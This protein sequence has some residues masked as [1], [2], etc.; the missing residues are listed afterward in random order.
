MVV[1]ATRDRVEKELS[2][3]DGI[4]RL[5]PAWVGRDLLPSGRRLG[6]PDDAY[7]LGERGEMCE[8][9]LGSTTHA[10]NRVGPPDE[11][12]SYLALDGADG[13]TL[14]EA[15]EAAPV[16]IMGTEYASAHPGLSRLAKI[17]DYRGRL[18]LHLHQRQEHAALVGRHSKDEAYYFPPG[19]DLGPHPETFL[20]VHPS[21]VQDEDYEVLLPY[22]ED[23]DSDLILRHSTAYVQVPEEGF[24]VPSG[25]LHGPGTAL[26]IELQEDSDVFAML[27][28]LNHGKLISKELLWKDVSKEDREGKGERFI[29][30]LIDWE[31]NGDPYLY[32]NHHL[33]PQIIE[34]S[35]TQSG[36]EH[37]IYYNTTKFS[38]KKLV[39]HP[40]CSYVTV[41]Q[42]VYNILVWSGS[43]TYGGVEVDGG[44]PGRDELLVTHDRAVAGVEVRNNGLDDL[45]VIKFFGPDVNP[46]VP[47]I[48]RR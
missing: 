12:L 15:V 30:E 26:T 4:L 22:L 47:M 23:W 19:V 1:D 48:E 11:G 20:G 46:D 25:V 32:E 38:G 8:R 29:L 31:E 44:M 16:A 41:D 7:D 14:K 10:D 18:P 9:W 28:A 35:R 6:L 13:I 17:F 3:T 24:H 34:D 42:G 43:G 5:E 33:S 21:I 36:E 39:V 2:D 45:S 40:G 37:W 27:Q